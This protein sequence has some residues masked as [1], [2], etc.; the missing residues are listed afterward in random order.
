MSAALRSI[1]PVMLVGAGK[2]GLALA[3]GWLDAGLPPSNLLLV[4]PNPG[5]AARELAEDYGLTLNSEAVGLQPNVLVLAVKPQ[6]ADTV[7]ATLAPVVGPQTLAISIAAGI[8]IARLSRGLGMGRVVRTMPNTPAQIGKGITGAVAGPEVNAQDRDTAEAL[9]R[10]AGPVVWFDDER[11]LDAVTAVSGSGPAYVFHLVEAL[12]AA[13]K[14][15]GL[16]DAI[17]EQLARQTVIG[18][19]ALLEADPATPAVLRQ[20]VTSP[21]GTT[22]AGLAVLMGD[23]GL[24][25]LIDRTVAAARQRSEELGRG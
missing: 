16:P 25:E 9:L 19:A 20:N 1:G 8:D 5:D 4:D 15:Q 11:Q 24:T 7:M 12:A 17:A 14:A 18:S 23:N 13:G 22:A 10:A 2:M 3:R 6:I 21:N